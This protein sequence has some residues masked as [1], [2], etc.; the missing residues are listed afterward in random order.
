MG[1]WWRQSGEEAEDGAAPVGVTPDDEFSTELTE[2][3]KLELIDRSATGYTL[4]ARGLLFADEV[5]LRFA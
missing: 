5:L 3:E 4:T 1:S 2:L